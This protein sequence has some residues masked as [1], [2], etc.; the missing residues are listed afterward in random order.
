MKLAEFGVDEPIRS[1]QLYGT[2][3][4][5]CPWRSDVEDRIGVDH[6]D[7]NFGCLALKVT[8]AVA[9]SRERRLLA[10]IAESAVKAAGAIPATIAFRK[11]ID[12]EHLTF[13]V[14]SNSQGVWLRE[15]SARPNCR[16]RIPGT[17]IGM[18]SE[19]W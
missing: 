6:I 4:K 16:D 11:G 10:S 12:D 18:P 5:Y 13:F 8:N 7:M 2:D 19:S 14:R 3:P 9:H 1:I 17:Q 15:S